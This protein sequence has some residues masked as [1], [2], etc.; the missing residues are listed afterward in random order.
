MYQLWYSKWTELK[1]LIGLTAILPKIKL[2]LSF[3]VWQWFTRN[4]HR[5]SLFPQH[6]KKNCHYLNY[7]FIAPSNL[8]FQ[9]CMCSPFIYGASNTMLCSFLLCKLKIIYMPFV[10]FLE[11]YPGSHP[12]LQCPVS[13]SHW[14]SF[15]QWLLQFWKQSIPNLPST[16]ATT[17]KLIKTLQCSCLTSFR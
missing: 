9:S 12:M 11:A 3:K 14:E 6:L 8:Q 7:H 2:L 5:V 1:I 16:H 4:R 17:W 10:Q 15:R 13:L